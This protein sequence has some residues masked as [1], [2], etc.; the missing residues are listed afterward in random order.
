MIGDKRSIDIKMHKKEYLI[1]KEKQHGYGLGCARRR[2]DAK[3]W[4]AKK[5][6]WVSRNSI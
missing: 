4:Q 2:W 1:G 3:R 5:T 6:R